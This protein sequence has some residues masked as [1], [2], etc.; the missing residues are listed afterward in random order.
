MLGIP[1]VIINGMT[2]SAAYEIGSKINRE[3]MGAQWNAIYLKGG[4][5]FIDAFWASACVVGRKSKDWKMVDSEGNYVDEDEE[6]EGTTEHTVNE[7]YFMTDPEKFIWTHFPDDVEWQLMEKTISEKDFE[8]HVYIRERFYSMGIK[9][10]DKKLYK[11]ILIPTGGEVHIQLGI[12]SDRSKDYQFKYMMYRNKTDEDFSRRLLL[13]KFVLMEHTNTH[14]KLSLRFPLKGKYKLDVYGLDETKTSDFDLICSYVVECTEP[15]K[16]CLPLPDTPAIGWGPGQETREAGILPKSHQGAYHC[17]RGW[18]SGHQTWCQ[19]GRRNTPAP[20]EHQ[21]RRGNTQQVR[22]GQRGEWRAFHSSTSSPRR[23]V[24]IEELSAASRT[25]HLEKLKN[26]IKRAKEANYDGILNLQ[27]VTA[28]RLKEKLVRIEKL[29]HNILVMDQST[30]AELRTY[31]HPPD[32]VR[33]SI[34]AVLMLLEY[35]KRDVKDWKAC[36]NILSRTGKESLMRRVAM[37]DPK[38]CFL[39]IALGAKKVI[40]PFSLEEIRDVSNGAAAFYNWASGMIKEVESTGGAS[41]PMDEWM[42]VTE[43][44]QGVEERVSLGPASARSRKIERQSQLGE[45]PMRMNTQLSI[46]RTYTLPSQ[47]GQR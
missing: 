6:D 2:K 24:R 25:R 44:V 37:F 35:P 30:A 31:T 29:R 17:Y 45:A 43:D 13:D 7:F 42:R 11:Q 40:E 23:R 16:N 27:I 8:E 4:W 26:A 28:E 36:Q 46:N 10:E 9:I 39:D 34:M 1:C 38:Y 21:H 14:L 41:R 22:C 20:K 5:R 12:P 15:K 19:Q 47:N 18:T 32:G 33:Q 3:N